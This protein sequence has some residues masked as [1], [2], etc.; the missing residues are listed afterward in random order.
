[1]TDDDA[2]IPGTDAQL[3]P[4]LALCLA[5]SFMME[6]GAS[7]VL[8][9]EGVSYT[10]DD[11]MPQIAAALGPRLAQLVDLIERTDTKEALMAGLS[12]EFA[13][14]MAPSPYGTA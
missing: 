5:L 14:L 6:D 2:Q 7:V 13:D 4:S 9:H 8:Q 11:L 10:A 12:D 3:G 1:M